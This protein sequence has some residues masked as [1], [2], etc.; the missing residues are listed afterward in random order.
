MDQSEQW[1]EQPEDHQTESRLSPGHRGDPQDDGEP[2]PQKNRRRALWRQQRSGQWSW[3][4]DESGGFCVSSG[5]WVVLVQG[6]ISKCL[7]GFWFHLEETEEMKARRHFCFLDVKLLLLVVFVPIQNKGNSVFGPV[8]GC[9]P[10]CLHVFFLLWTET[11]CRSKLHRLSLSE[12]WVQIISYCSDHHQLS[13]SNMVWFCSS[14]VPLDEA[15]GVEAVGQQNARDSIFSLLLT[16]YWRTRLDHQLQH[17][18]LLKHWISNVN[19]FWS[20]SYH[21]LLMFSA[22]IE[23]SCGVFNMSTD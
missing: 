9:R 12:I 3:H 23:S 5:H 17:K 11:S 2:E 16:F 18:I 13:Q 8:V 7:C 6:Q 4:H 15:F 22:T 21:F 10:S 1:A 19:R 14:H 20:G